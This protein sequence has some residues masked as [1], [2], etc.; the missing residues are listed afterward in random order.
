MGIAISQLNQTSKP[1]LVID[2]ND[3][4]TTNQQIIDAIVGNIINY[5][6]NCP[7]TIAITM[8]PNA[9][10]NLSNP[11]DDSLL[12][13]SQYIDMKCV[14]VASLT[15]DIDSITFIQIL[16][17]II[18]ASD[19]SIVD[20]LN[21]AAGASPL[22]HT[23]PAFMNSVEAKNNIMYSDNG[24]DFIQSY[25]ALSNLMANQIASIFTLAQ[26]TNCMATVI[27]Q[28]NVKIYDSTTNS[29]LLTGIYIDQANGLLTTCFNIVVGNI[30]NNII[31][32]I[33]PNIPNQYGQ[34][35]YI[36]IPDDQPPPTVPD[37][38]CVVSGWNR[39]VCVDTSQ[40][41]YTRVITTASSGA[42]AGCPVL[43]EYVPD[44]TCQ[45]V[46][47][48]PTPNP[49][50]NIDCVVSAWNRDVCANNQRRY[51]RS[52]TTPS[53]GSGA[54]CPALVE[55][56]Q[57]TTCEP[58]APNQVSNIDCMVSAWNRDVC[59]NNQRRY[60]RNITIPSSGSGAACPGLVEY[61]PDSTCMPE[62]VYI[63]VG[64]T[65]GPIVNPLVP[66]YTSETSAKSEIQVEIIPIKS[67]GEQV[68]LKLSESE[69]ETLVGSI[70]SMLPDVLPDVLLNIYVLGLVVLMIILCLCLC[71]C[72]IS[73]IGPF[74]RD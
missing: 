3:I 10:V 64:Q 36:M 32:V 35:E 1:V 8:N 65:T 53:S 57:D 39:D 19:S 23:V 50:S 68:I 43:V 41:K 49:V 73:G 40:R 20:Q 15:N 21:T 59:E 70:T 29:T 33:Q 31:N 62:N 14:S 26:I 56:V 66:I 51:T 2:Q 16:E 48:P 28:Q 11:P 61:K 44:T 27:S 69:S 47:Q 6:Q 72:A 18:M 13:P 67:E 54:G 12:D 74:N 9:T 55:Y 37:V 63:T 71:C 60:T 34:I 38:N 58:P 46:T 42:G 5:A 22:S 25:P 24:T 17:N 30:I 4:N 45:P 7:S 52:I